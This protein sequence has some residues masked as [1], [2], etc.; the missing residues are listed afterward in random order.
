MSGLNMLDKSS[1]KKNL[2]HGMAVAGFACLDA[3]TDEEVMAAARSDSDALPS[4]DYPPG[5]LGIARRVP[6]ARALR[7]RLKLSQ[8]AFA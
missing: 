1:E 2:V 3:M 7:F 6:F 8:S 4:E 5:R